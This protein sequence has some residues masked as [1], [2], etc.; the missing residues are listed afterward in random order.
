MLVIYLLVSV[1]LALCGTEYDKKEE[2]DR[3]WSRH[4]RKLRNLEWADELNQ[5]A[6]DARNGATIC[7][8]VAL[9]SLLLSIA[10]ALD[11]VGYEW[12]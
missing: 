9:I 5:S 12:R 3:R 1:A 4:Q 11:T 10:E 2:H 8:T 6:N 7:Y